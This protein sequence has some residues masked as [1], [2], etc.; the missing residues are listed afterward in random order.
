MFPQLE[1]ARID[2]DQS[3]PSSREFGDVYY[4]RSSGLAES[5]YVF[6]EQNHLSERFAQLAKEDRSHFTIAETGF[7]TGLNFLL[8]WSL[9]RQYSQ[10]SSAVLHFIS[11]ERWPLSRED[12]ATSLSSWPELQE[13]SAQL[14]EVYPPALQGFHRLV[15]DQGRVRLTLLLGDATEQLEKAVFQAD[16][17]FLDGFAP[18]K[19]PELWT[20]RLFDLIQQRSAAGTTFATFTAAGVI[21][22]SLQERGFTVEKVPGFG[23]KREM[24]R[25]LYQSDSGPNYSALFHS[26]P[27]LI[28]PAPS[29]SRQAIIIGAGLAGAN[30]AWNL[31]SRG[32]QVRVY[33]QDGIA[34]G[35]SGNPQG[36]L[37]AKLG[38]EYTPQT[39]LQIASL[40]FSQRFYGQL[41]Q[42]TPQADFWHPCGVLQLAHNANEQERQHKFLARNQYPSEIFYPVTAEEGSRL[43]GTRVAQE[44]LFFPKSGYVR[45]AVLCESLLNAAHVAVR[46]QHIEELRYDAIQQSWQLLGSGQ[47][48]LD[49]A[50]VVILATASASLKFSQAQGLPLKS[51]RG[52]I[53]LCPQPKDTALNSVICGEGYVS[54]PRN[55]FL[56]TGATFQHNND[57]PALEAADHESNL[58]QLAQLA[59]ALAVES[60]SVNIE[61]LNGRV[62]FRCASTDFTP[63]V[64]P[65]SNEEIAHKA[66]PDSSIQSDSHP[67]YWPGLYISTAHGSK[68][69]ATCPLSAELLADL[70]C[71][72][73]LCVESDLYRILSPLRFWA[74]RQAK[75]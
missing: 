51:I 41:A 7:G 53:T 33:D 17:W 37:Y 39:R 54:P 68:G 49:Q 72:Q 22:R 12:L 31:Y 45:P 19:N 57:N 16:A 55:G 20:P 11:M 46:T 70:I 59:P 58:Q 71:G 75:P 5:Q 21:R 10:S 60:D 73:P 43:A 30:L 14:L 50:P 63:L 40:L 9:W 64:G 61:Q 65:L 29:S 44:G 8:T 56:C 35:A 13:L 62:G 42:T 24:L 32:W 3:H 48:I 28:P 23:R 18:A 34:S 38:V 74:R 66:L 15:L 52:Q 67:P 26:Q 25:G 36:A 69:L 47:E 27:W 6:L 4:D 2:W 1:N